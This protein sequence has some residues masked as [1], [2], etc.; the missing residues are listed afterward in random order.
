MCPGAH[1][2]RLRR[3]GPPSWCRNGSCWSD[4]CREGAEPLPAGE[5]CLLPWPA[6]A[7]GEYPLPGVP[8]QPRG[9][10]PDPVAE[11]VRVG[12]AEFPV[13]TEAEE[14]GPG[15]QVGGDVRRDDPAAV[16]LRAP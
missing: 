3:G 16:D 15:G 6:G 7:D 8:G 5:E 11:C 12:V 13:V 4:G 2:L 10:V 9:D 14:A 1:R